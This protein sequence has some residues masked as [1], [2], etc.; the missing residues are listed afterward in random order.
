MKPAAQRPGSPGLAALRQHWNALAPRQKA[1]AGVTVGVL[2][3]AAL[4]WLALAPALATLREAPAQQQAL[5]A[6]LQRMQTLQAQAQALQAL[7]RIG[8]DEAQ[9]ALEATV[10]EQLGPGARLAP[11]GEDLALNLS[12]VPGDALAR[13]LTQARM[14]AG[15]LPTEARLNRDAS[16]LWA[17]SL[18]LALPPR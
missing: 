4:W 14:E 15:A 9:R 11:S 12:R 17:G 13:W 2:V 3:F 5:D 8:R 1:L 6:Q 7:P 18:V 16:G 10:R